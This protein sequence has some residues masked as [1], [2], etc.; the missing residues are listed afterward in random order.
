MMQEYITP[1]RTANAICQDKSFSGFIVLVEGKKDLKFYGRFIDKKVARLVPTFGKYNLR[2]VFL[3]LNKRNYTRKIAV[4][5]ADF[6]RIKNNPKFDPNYSENIFPTDYHDSEIMMVKSHACRNFLRITLDE[7]KLDAYEK[8]I[9]CLIRDLAFRL[10][11]NIGCLRLANKTYNLGLSFKPE[12]PEGNRIKYKNFICNRTGE[13]LGDEKLVNTV[14]EYSKNRD[15]KL[16]A[17]VDVEEKLKIILLERHPA[18][19]IVNGHDITEILAIIVRDVLKSTSQLLRSSDCVEDLLIL[20]FDPNEF[21]K[22]HLRAKL[23][24]WENSVGTN[25][26]L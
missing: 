10:S 18:D 1:D 24:A 12:K 23:L 25:I 8:K 11:Y 4:R 17:K 6:L 14:H 22:T 20:G 15:T 13:F 2:E 3:L 19:E 16:A 26:I 7:E 9:G 5:D 21:S